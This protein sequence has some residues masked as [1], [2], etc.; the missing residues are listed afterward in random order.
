MNEE[1]SV[2]VKEGLEVLFLY[3]GIGIT[4][5][6]TV[7]SGIR[8]AFGIVNHS[9]A[10]D[11]VGWYQV[12]GSTEMPVSA[13][14]L[15]V[16]FIVLVIILRKTRGT[17][18][19]YQ[20]T[21]WY[22]LCRTII[23]IILT[24]A[25]GMI[26]VAVSILFGDILSGEIALNNFLKTAIVSVSGAAI[27][28]Y[29]RGVLHGTWRTQKERERKFAVATSTAIGLIVVGAG[30]IFNPFAQSELRRT[31]EKL[32]CVQSVSMALDSGYRVTEELPETEIYE[33]FI[34]KHAEYHRHVWEEECREADISYKRVDATHYQLCVSLE[35]LPEG[36]TM[37]HYPYHQFMVEKIGENCFDREVRK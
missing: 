1:S 19:E 32:A 29:Y 30:L 6:F 16:S 28:Y 14:F 34:R 10:A 12:Y 35:T 37:K 23:F 9:I 25:I 2:K 4:L 18:N 31:H 22:T 27:F 13:S 3:I 11:S 17:V 5:L 20:G 8:T 33:E 21:V 15:L 36:V 24:A 7:I 26:A